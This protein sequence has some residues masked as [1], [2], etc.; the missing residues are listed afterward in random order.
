MPFRS[1]VCAAQRKRGADIDDTIHNDRE[2]GQND[3]GEDD[4]AGDLQNHHE[5][6]KDVMS[7]P[8][9]TIEIKFIPQAEQRYDTCGDFFRDDDGVVHFRISQMGDPAYEMAVLIHELA[10]F[11][12]C[13]QDGVTIEQVDA[14][15]M[16]EGKDLDEPG[17]DPRAPY[18]AQHVFAT[19]VERAFIEG[20]GITW[21]EYDAAVGDHGAMD[22]SEIKE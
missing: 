8:I 1:W 10:E 17:N 4:A 16:G 22:I 18:H 21:D 6:L 5:P 9:R 7:Q 20:M 19:A 15:D 11:I 14:W 3:H 12:R 2:D 13:E